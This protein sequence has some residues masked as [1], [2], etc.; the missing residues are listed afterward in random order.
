MKTDKELDRVSRT[1]SLVLR[2][3]PENIGIKLD[4]EGWTDVKILLKKLDITMANLEWIVDTNNKKRFAFNKD[5]SKIRASQ[6]H[7][8]DIDLALKRCT[9]VPEQLYHGTS[10]ET[11]KIIMSDG[12]KKMKRSHVHLSKDYDTA[13]TVGKR[14]GNS[15]KVLNIDSKKMLDDG[16]EIYLSDNGVYLT[17][18]VHPK[19]LCYVLM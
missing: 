11:A 9:E 17:D 4:K 7:S 6:G 2:H 10:H 3:K 18:Y 8:V 19:Y 16:H 5:K 13:Y 12:I 15:V 1:M 14:K